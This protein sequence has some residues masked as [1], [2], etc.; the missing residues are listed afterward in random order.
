[1]RLNP[2]TPAILSNS[3]CFVINNNTNNSNCKVSH[4]FFLLTANAIPMRCITFTSIYRTQIHTHIMC[5]YAISIL[6]AIKEKMIFFAIF[7]LLTLRVFASV[8]AFLSEKKCLLVTL[9]CQYDFKF[10]FIFT[11]V[12]C[13]CTANYFITNDEFW[14]KIGFYF[15]YSLDL[16]FEASLSWIFRNYFRF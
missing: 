11:K 6:F 1:M 7:F 10:L 8:A 2:T 5:H 9:T 14:K 13:S 4:Y 15:F 3:L 12:L 16:D